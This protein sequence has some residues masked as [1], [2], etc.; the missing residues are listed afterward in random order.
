MIEPIA[1]E[2]HDVCVAAFVIGMA[3][4]AILIERV[5]LSTVI[6]PSRLAVARDLLVADKTQSRLAMARI[7]F[8]ALAAFLL[9]LGVALHHRS[10]V[11]SCSATSAHRDA[12]CRSIAT[13]SDSE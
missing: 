3:L 1:I 4:P 7:G 8:V 13:P 5:G 2:L 6:A 10:S 12:G 11:T 9:V